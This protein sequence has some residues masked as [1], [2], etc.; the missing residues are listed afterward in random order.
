MPDQDELVDFGEEP[1]DPASIALE[2]KYSK[3]MRRIVSQKIDL[4]ISTLPEMIKEHLQTSSGEIGGTS[5]DRVRAIA[6]EIDAHVQEALRSAERP[7]NSGSARNNS[8][9]SDGHTEWLFGIVPQKGGREVISD[10]CNRAVPFNDLPSR[11]RI[12]HYWGGAIRL[13]EITR[14]EKSENPVSTILCR[15]SRMQST[16]RQTILY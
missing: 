13:R 16:L 12:T 15:R 5:L 11:I 10:V 1:V 9:C 8:L 4:P 3:E 6:D 14:Q 7:S 2:Q